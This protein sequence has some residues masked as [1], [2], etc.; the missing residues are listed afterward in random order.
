MKPQQH[1]T[2]DIIMKMED[3]QQKAIL[4]KNAALE[5]ENHTV[6]AEQEAMHQKA[7]Q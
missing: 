7:A 3:Y 6:K 2:K 1:F 4:L 5:M